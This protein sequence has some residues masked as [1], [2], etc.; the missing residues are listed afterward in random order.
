MTELAAGL[1]LGL[2]GSAHCLAMC[3]P[4]AWLAGRGRSSAAYHASRIATYIVLGAL[5]GWAGAALA[6]SGLARGLAL[7]AGVI[8][9][10]QSAGL[11]GRLVRWMPATPIRRLVAQLASLSLEMP[12][13]SAGKAAILGIAN[14][15]IPC[16]LLYAALVTAAGLGDLATAMTFVAGFGM[17][18]LPVFAG[19]ALS[20]TFLR[21]RA[22]RLLRRA[23]PVALILAGLMMLARA[24]PEVSGQG[25]VPHA[26]HRLG[27][28]LQPE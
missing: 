27:S 22:P 25:A 16:G 3:G 26:A 4:L 12:E 14:G 15:L 11:P 7:V 5:A 24:W 13:R 20:S 1:L 21:A 2:A 17:G 18:S 6:D 19:L 9:I 10:A 8:L 28:T 23:M